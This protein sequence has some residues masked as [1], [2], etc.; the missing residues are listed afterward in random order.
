[1]S[2]ENV[3]VVRRANAAFNSGDATASLDLWAPDAELRD[4]GNAPDQARVVNGREAIQKVGELWGAAFE[5]FSAEI[6]EYIDGGDFVV[7]SVRWHGQGKASGASIDLHQFDVYELG[8]GQIVRGTLG[9]RTRNDALH[10]AGLSEAVGVEDNVSIVR[11]AHPPSGTELTDWFAQGST[12][13][14]D[15]GEVTS[16]YAADFEFSVPSIGGPGARDSG[17][18]LPALFETWREWL[19]PWE[20]YWTEVEEFVDAGN[21]RVVVL[22]RDHGRPRGGGAEVVQSAASVWTVDDGRIARID[23]YLAWA[24]ALK[25][26][27]LAE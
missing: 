15:S 26:A 24:E 6:D 23:F 13:W 5:E 12:T 7:C 25:A 18:G 11:A 27:R 14:V 16:P 9:F 4:L 20:R 3:E 8:G 21:S 1:M 19:E 22:L 2:Q 10:A 17:R